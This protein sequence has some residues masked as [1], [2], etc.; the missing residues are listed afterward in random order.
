MIAVKPDIGYL[1]E[2]LTSAAEWLRQQLDSIDCV[3]FA[4]IVLT[5]ED[6]KIFLELN[7]TAIKVRE[8]SKGHIL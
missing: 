6:G 5:N 7:Q 4:A 1:A 3:A 8:I 2:D